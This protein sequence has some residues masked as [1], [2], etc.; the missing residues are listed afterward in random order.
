MG[1]QSEAGSFSAKEEPGRRAG[2]DP[3]GDGRHQIGEH[4]GDESDDVDVHDRN[5]WVGDG[6]DRAG[7]ED[8]EPPPDDDADR[9]A[10]EDSDRRRRHRRLPGHHRGELTL[11]ETES[12]EKGKITAALAD[13]RD[14]GQGQRCGGPAARAAARMAGVAPIV[15]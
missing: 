12:A 10:E 3:S 1:C 7:E 8:P 11:K 2:R 4:E 9:H 6:V 5:G 13:R 14:Q 15:R